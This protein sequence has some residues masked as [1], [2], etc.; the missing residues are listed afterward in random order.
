MLFAST[1]QWRPYKCIASGEGS[2]VPQADFYFFT[3]SLSKRSFIIYDW[4]NWE[5][6]KTY[7]PWGDYSFHGQ[8]IVSPF[9]NGK[10]H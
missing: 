6:P 4:P 7:S 5:T 2:F 9:V 1:I 3:R 8:E 10:F